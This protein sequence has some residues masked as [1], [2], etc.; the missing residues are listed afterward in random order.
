M[1]AFQKSPVAVAVAVTVGSTATATGANDPPPVAV[2]AAAVDQ[3]QQMCLSMERCTIRCP[4]QT[5]APFTLYRYIK[6]V[7]ID[8]WKQLLPRFYTFLP[9]NYPCPNHMVE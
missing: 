6:P 2:A 7:T 1:G 3:Q 9:T 5:G 4:L 8:S